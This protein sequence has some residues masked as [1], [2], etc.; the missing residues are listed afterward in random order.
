MWSGSGPIWHCFG[1]VLTDG[2]LSSSGTVRIRIY[3]LHIIIC[4]AW[5]FLYL[6]VANIISEVIYFLFNKLFKAMLQSS[7]VCLFVFLLGLV[8][9]SN[10]KP[11][12][13]SLVPSVS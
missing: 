7:Y 11:N 9:G 6:K 3:R 8:L 10:P 2:L 5:A 13:K 4:T 1:F 12:Q